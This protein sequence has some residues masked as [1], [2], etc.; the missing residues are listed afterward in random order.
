MVSGG[1]V[2]GMSIGG[3]LKV[4]VISTQGG[5]WPAEGREPSTEDRVETGPCR[6]GLGVELA[7]RIQDLLTGSLEGGMHRRLRTVSGSE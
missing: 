7:L 2:G 5:R 4:A 1:G 3:A 6:P